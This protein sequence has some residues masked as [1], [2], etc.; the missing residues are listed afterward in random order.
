MK[1]ERQ[2]QNRFLNLFNNGEFYMA[3]VYFF[4]A[5]ILEI[6]QFLWMGWGVMPQYWLL[7]IALLLMI[8]GFVFVIPK[9]MAKQIVYILFLLIP[10]LLNIVNV[11]LFTVF[12]SVLNINMLKLG[13]EAKTAFSFSFLNFWN[14]AVNVL[15]FGLA[16]AA[17]IIIP[18]KIKHK[19]FR[20]ENKVS[21]YAFI[22]A[23][24]LII[25]YLGVFGFGYTT[26]NLVTAESILGNDAYLY[27]T[28]YITNESYKKFGTYGYYFKAI[29]TYT[30]KSK[31]NDK[32]DL[33]AELE[34]LKNGQGYKFSTEKSGILE[35]YNVVTILLESFD[36]FAVNP[37]FTPTMW[38]LQNN[39]GVGFT[40]F[41][42]KNKT[43]I[44]EAIALLG[45]APSE[46]LP[47]QYYDNVGLCFPTALPNLVKQDA[48]SKNQTVKTG[49]YHSYL[50]NFY[51]RNLTHI[52][53]GFD[54]ILGLEEVYGKIPTKNFDDRILEADCFNMI[55]DKIL[56]TDV[57]RFYSQ[58]TTFSSHGSYDVRVSAFKEYED[59]VDLHYDE[60]CEFLEQNGYTIPTDVT[61]IKELKTYLARCIDTDNLIKNLLNELEERN[62]TDNTLILM[63]AD[64]APYYNDLGVRVKGISKNE[65]YN[66]RQNNLP[67][68]MWAKDLEP[69]IFESFCSHYDI[70]PTICDLLGLPV[71]IEITQGQSIFAQDRSSVFVS[72]LN[73][74]YNNKLYSDNIEDVIN[75]EGG[76]VEESVE[77]SKFRNDAVNFYLKQ[78]FIEKVWANNLFSKL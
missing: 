73:G 56:P 3:V 33:K 55:M 35:N 18:K 42:G 78:E 7:D 21:R 25:E 61:F 8:S 30:N 48:Q 31:I 22:L 39:S 28:L 75:I 10:T 68:I 47:K 54:E 59:Y 65:Y 45:H 34:K 43:N 51:G 24:F 26:T 20:P 37:Y 1:N 12:G 19:D 76:S 69:Q 44:S 70:Y 66:S 62:L 63:Y 50:S 38:D 5:L 6:V 11:T 67:L 36:T 53:F 74:I 41:Y 52:E 2:K 32:D 13:N 40:N 16:V 64:H 46:V 72:F 71:N 60:Y 15:I 49:F 17:I 57:D 29:Q 9:T 77:I 4:A 23:F 27:S 58:I 14:I